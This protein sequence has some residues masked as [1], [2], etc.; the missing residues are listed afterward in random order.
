MEAVVKRQADSMAEF[1]SLLE[2]SFDYHNTEG[3][4][5][6]SPEETRVFFSNLVEAS[7]GFMEHLSITCM[8]KTSEMMVKTVVAGM[9]AEAS[10]DMP[11]QVYSALKL[12]V[13]AD[14]REGMQAEMAKAREET[15]RMIEDY[16][17]NKEERDAA[18]F[19]ALDTNGD[20]TI[21]RE[22]FKEAFTPGTAK[23]SQLMSTLGLPP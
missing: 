12:Q 19:E 1:V 21:E 17:A 14:V 15:A 16:V 22:E 9:E 18:A 20:G 3:T 11:P 8:R 6:L 5:V 7:G 2:Q 10:P 13:I 4:G 23:N